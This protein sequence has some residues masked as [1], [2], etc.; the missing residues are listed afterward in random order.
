MEHRREKRGDSWDQSRAVSVCVGGESEINVFI[1]KKENVLVFANCQ[2]YLLNGFMTECVYIFKGYHQSYVCLLPLTSMHPF[3]A[4]QRRCSSNKC[5]SSDITSERHDRT[6]R[7]MF[8]P[9]MKEKL[10]KSPSVIIL[11]SVCIVTVL[12]A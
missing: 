8:L 5:S 11:V 9:K 12:Q 1:W 10:T 6:T 2:T 4:T 7:I 3:K